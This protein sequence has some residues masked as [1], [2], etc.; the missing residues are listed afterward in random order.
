[1][2]TG[3]LRPGEAADPA[4]FVDLLRHL[5]DRSRL[6]FRQLEQHAVAAGDVLARSTA[7]D[8]LRRSTLPRPEVLAAFVRACGAGDQVDEWLRA[9]DRLAAGGYAAPAAFAT[10]PPT[11]AG[12]VLTGGPDEARSWWFARPAPLAAFVAVAV[13]AAFGTWF[14]WPDDD[15]Q[16][17]AEKPAATSTATPGG[18]A[19]ASG[20]GTPPAGGRSR[21]RPAQA[22]QLCISE[23]RDRSGGYKDAVAVQRPCAGATPP[24]TY[25]VPVADYLY[26]VKWEHPVH[27][28]GCLTVRQGDPGRNLIE[29]RNKCS[30]DTAEQLFRFEPTGAAPDAYRLRPSD[31]DLCVGIQDDA[32]EV[33]AEA[34]AEPCTGQPDQVFLVDAV[35]EG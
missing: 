7:A 13:L 11:S 30:A 12:D 16:R 1:M 31:S 23:G 5:K 9:R 2:T 10:A 21:I 19:S 26:F 8:V 27:G 14:L 17:T 20:T 35:P 6:T 22:P 32:S 4:E 24:E 29:P 28:A 15:E 18:S 33:P 34:A 3:D 25:L